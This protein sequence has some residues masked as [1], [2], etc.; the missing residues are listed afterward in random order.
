MILAT[1]IE[2]ELRKL[3]RSKITWLSFVFYG[4]FALMAWFVLWIV[5][6]P[7][8]AQG[9]GLIGQKASFA[10]NGISADWQGLLTFFAEMGMMGG[11]IVLA[12][13]VI[14]LFGREYV[15]GTAK[16][17]LALPIRRGSFVAAKLVVAAA[18]FALL[19]L[20]LV[21]ESLLV[22]GL[23][24]LGALPPG[25]LARACEG[26]LFPALLVYALQP[27][28]AWVTVAS[29]GYLAPFG[30]TIATILVGNLMV[31]TDWARWC[32]W[33]IVALLGGLAGPRQEGV[34]AGSFL[35]LAATFAL[36]VAGTDL[37][38]KW[39]DNCQ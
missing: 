28:V 6:N 26:I 33:S 12:F 30:Y 3:K 38:L 37:H 5:K 10:S 17:M 20:F 8:A 27:L 14:Y 16:N 21:A 4:F 23:L 24:G 25:F 11:M 29:G 7:E 36:G 2:T 39:A 34:A 1:V 31:R 18:W 19:T 32:P 9:L 15:E 13:I 35:V 22:G